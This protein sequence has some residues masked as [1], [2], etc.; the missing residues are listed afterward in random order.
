MG[1]LDERQTS[2]EERLFRSRSAKGAMGRGAFPRWLVQNRTVVGPCSDPVAW[3]LGCHLGGCR[4]AGL[5]RVVVAPSLSSLLLKAEGKE[6]AMPYCITLRSRADFTVTGWY[7]GSTGRWSTDHKRQ[8]L[9][10]KRH[11]ARGI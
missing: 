3:A 5:G 7:D 2:V 11:D 6:C 4:R 9:F 8:K 10:D 1:R